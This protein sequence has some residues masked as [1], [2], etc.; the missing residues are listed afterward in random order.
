MNK[1]RNLSFY[2]DIINLL[3]DEGDP[4]KWQDN[5]MSSHYM[6]ICLFS[7]YRKVPISKIEYYVS[8][9]KVNYSLIRAIIDSQDLSKKR[10]L[11][12]NEMNLAETDILKLKNFTGQ[13]DI[14]TPIDD[15]LWKSKMK[16][17]KPN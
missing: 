6:F 13:K 8:H 9:A 17:K 5:P 10:V 3:T 12:N 4:S 14:S 2:E 15:S 16:R 11:M 7:F 1:H